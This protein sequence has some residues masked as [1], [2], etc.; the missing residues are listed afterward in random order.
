MGIKPFNQ[1]TDGDKALQTNYG[2]GKAQKDIP[3]MR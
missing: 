1:T 2:W 3:L